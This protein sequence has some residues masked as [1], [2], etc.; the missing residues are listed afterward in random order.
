KVRYGLMTFTGIAGQ[1]CPLIT[2]TDIAL[3]G[4]AD[5]KAAYDAASMKP[6][7]KLETPTGL[8]I[9]EKAVPK[10]SS[11][12]DPGGKYIVFV[13]DGEPDRCDDGTPECAR[14]DVVRAVQAAHAKGITTLVF[15]LGPQT[16]A[17]HLQDVANAGAGQP[18][19]FPADN[20]KFACFGGDW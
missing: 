5:I 7:S 1:E 6:G 16:Y 8:T 2:E 12:Q 13:T 19:G 9:N 11:V 15:G 4:Y 17:Q 10:L 20:A 14:D 3:Q 18:V